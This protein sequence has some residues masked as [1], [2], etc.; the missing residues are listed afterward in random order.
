MV[1]QERLATYLTDHM[2]GSAAARDLVARASSKSEGTPLGAFLDSLRQEIEAD[3]KEL[4][5]IMNRFGVGESSV[6]EAAG[7]LLE[8][9]SRLKFEELTGAGPGVNRV[10]ELEALLMGIRGKESL[11]LTLKE[12]A[13]SEPRLADTDYDRLIGRALQQQADVER[14]RLEIVP[15][16]FA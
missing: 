16:A 5:A 10:L 2:A 11:W 14:H 7:A 13:A 6:K 9:V 15:T 8:K 4:A 12:L 3:R 1:T